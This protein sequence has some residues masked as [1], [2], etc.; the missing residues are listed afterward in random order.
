MV[1]VY[2]VKQVPEN[3]STCLYGRSLGCGHAD[4][5]KDW[6]YYGLFGRDCP[7]YWLDQHRFRRVDGRVLRGSDYA[8]S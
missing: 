3:C 8:D 5:Q 4:R 2:E 1:E 6:M 7:S